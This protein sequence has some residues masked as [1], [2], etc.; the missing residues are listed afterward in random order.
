[1][2][3]NLKLAFLVSSLVASGTLFAQNTQ[4]S[5]KPSSPTQARPPVQATQGGQATGVTAAAAGQT[6]V[7][8]AGAG[9][10]GM[11]IPGVVAAGITAVGAATTTQSTTSH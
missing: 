9:I 6:G 11:G 5:Q 4:P 3:A 8:G 1:M 10:A 2:A 7:E